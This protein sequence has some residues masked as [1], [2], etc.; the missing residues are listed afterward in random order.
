MNLQSSLRYCCKKYITYMSIF[1]FVFNS[2]KVTNLSMK[3][4]QP[5]NQTYLG[6]SPQNKTLVIQILWSDK[7]L[8]P[9]IE[10]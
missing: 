6:D 5:K 7:Q 4:R 10:M 9:F 2:N 8:I 1:V 3:D